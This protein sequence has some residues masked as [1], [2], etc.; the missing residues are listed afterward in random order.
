MSDSVGYVDYVDSTSC[1]IYWIDA[2]LES[3]VFLFALIVSQ[4]LASQRQ[5]LIVSIATVVAVGSLVHI[6]LVLCQGSFNPAE[7]HSC[8]FDS[9]ACIA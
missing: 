7:L 9:A 5:G 2:S 1:A 6:N 3:S 8:E 4:L